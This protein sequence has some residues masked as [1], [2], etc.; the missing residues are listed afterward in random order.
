VDACVRWWVASCGCMCAVRAA[1]ALPLKLRRRSRGGCWRLRR[2]NRE[3]G[4]SIPCARRSVGA[5]LTAE[6]GGWTGSQDGR[7]AGRRPC[8]EQ[9]L[10]ALLAVIG[11]AARAHLGRLRLERQRIGSGCIV[12]AWG[13]GGTS[14]AARLGGRRLSGRLGMPS[15]RRASSSRCVRCPP[16]STASSQAPR[17]GNRRCPWPGLL[18]RA[19]PPS[20][21]GVNALSLFPLPFFPFH[22]YVVH[23][24]LLVFA[25]GGGC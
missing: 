22:T 16:A 25:F 2:R 19:A 6:R 23:P 7:C 10:A 8:R 5:V 3:G 4:A 20:C 12:L 24:A 1:A 14:T 17:I 15:P 9:L 18:L 21:S 13:A 11:A